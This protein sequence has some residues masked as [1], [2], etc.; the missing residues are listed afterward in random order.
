[1]DEDTRRRLAMEDAATESRETLEAGAAVLDAITVT[2]LGSL[3]GYL[4]QWADMQ[5]GVQTPRAIELELTYSGVHDY[6]LDRGRQFDAA[7]ALTADERDV[8]RAAAAEARAAWACTFEVRE[9]FW[10]AQL[11][12]MSDPTE[13]LRYCEGFAQG[14]LIP[15]HH[16]WVTINGKV[17]DLTW[18]R[19]AL[20]EDPEAYHAPRDA[21]D[22][23]ILGDAPEGFVYF[24]CD[25]YP[26]PDVMLERMDAH[27]VCW[28][29]LACDDVDETAARYSVDR[30]SPRP[31]MSPA[32][33]MMLEANGMLDAG[34]ES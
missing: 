7:T 21:L 28:S 14:H 29:F 30:V 10:N 23:R 13:A 5:W 15:V 22:R 25:D 16:A 8:V 18:R 3:R 24:G 34:G 20:A 2:P 17:V 11:L 19:V 6:V 32:V 31:A 4:R 26:G 33:R 27:D 9:C 1:M 12:A